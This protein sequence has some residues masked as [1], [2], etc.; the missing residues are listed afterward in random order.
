M[1]QT[2]KGIL[3]PIFCNNIYAAHLAWTEKHPFFFIWMSSQLASTLAEKRNLVTKSGLSSICSRP[4]RGFRG[5][6]VLCFQTSRGVMQWLV[7]S[8]GKRRW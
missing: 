2:Q 6:G 5:S 8:N 4:W 7:R 3:G 1:Q